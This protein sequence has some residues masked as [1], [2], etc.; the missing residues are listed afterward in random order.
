M[1]LRVL[2]IEEVATYF[3]SNGCPLLMTERR[4]ERERER[5]RERREKE[6]EREKDEPRP[7][8]VKPT[9]SPALVPFFHTTR[10][11]QFIV[12]ITKADSLRN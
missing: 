4:R 3:C 9:S 1:G 7:V 2:V 5:E 6:R 11:R 12:G 10:E 8:D